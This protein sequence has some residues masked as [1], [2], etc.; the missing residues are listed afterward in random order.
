VGNPQ[1]PQWQP[2]DSLANYK[3]KIR[4]ETAKKQDLKYKKKKMQKTTNPEQCH[5]P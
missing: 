2:N 1:L 3:E 5:C 4:K